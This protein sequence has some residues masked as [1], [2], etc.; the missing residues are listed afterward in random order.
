MYIKKRG[1]TGLHDANYSTVTLAKKS[2]AHGLGCCG[3][4]C[5]S[6]VCKE[7]QWSEIRCDGWKPGVVL[8]DQMKCSQSSLTV[9][10]LRNKLELAMTNTYSERPISLYIVSIGS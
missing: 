5:Q 6:R 2:V 1:A 3:I 10:F 4:G 9:R 7:V 8:G